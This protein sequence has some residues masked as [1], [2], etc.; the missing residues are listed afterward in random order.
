MAS[1]TPLLGK[2]LSCFQSLAA[3]EV[4]IEDALK[5]SL[6]DKLFFQPPSETTEWERSFM[7]A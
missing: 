3:I 6:G 4:L 2:D 1:T 5:L 7:G